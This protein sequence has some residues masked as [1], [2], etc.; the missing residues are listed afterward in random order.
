MCLKLNQGDT[1]IV[2]RKGERSKN[3][4]FDEWSWGY[5]NKSMKEGWFPTL[6]H[7][8]MVATRDMPSMGQGITGLEEGEML[9]ARRQRGKFFWG[10]SFQP[11]TKVL[12][13]K[14]KWY[15]KGTFAET[16]MIF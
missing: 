5:C 2:A 1:V 7:S 9:I 10:Y 6:A 11:G 15:E 13:S 4:P 3:A 12:D 14:L 16:L 8:L